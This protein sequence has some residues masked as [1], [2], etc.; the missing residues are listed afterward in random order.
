MKIGVIGFGNMAQA[1][2][3]GLIQYANVEGSSVYASAKNQNK[4]IEN[5]KDYQI[6]A[7]SNERVCSEADFIILAV[8]PYMVESVI[9][10]LKD[11]LKNKVVI[12]VIAG[13][14]F[15]KWKEILDSST[16]ILSTIPNTPIRVAK[17]IFIVE[18][19][20]NF[21][22]E[23]L[24]LFEQLFSTISTIEYVPTSLLS[25]VGSVCGCGPAFVDMFIEGLSDAAVLHGIPRAQSYRLISKMIEGSALLQNE[26]NLH[27]GVLKDQVCSP[28][29]T[30][31]IGVSTLEKNG[32]RYA[33]VDAINQIQKKK[34][35]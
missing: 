13:Y 1:I 31:I 8:K 35:N 27:P 9:T 30:T 34:S 21:S 4:L 23:N 5:T 18:D 25:I 14:S 32:F 15:D 22:D 28:N 6:I 24:N 19:N 17:G 2:V 16:Q 33:L 10:P 7:C 11:H 3:Y 20:H 26:S 29:G 12:S